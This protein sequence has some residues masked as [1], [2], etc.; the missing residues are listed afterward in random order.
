[1]AED[2]L[3]VVLLLG[4]AVFV[5]VFAAAVLLEMCGIVTL[6]LGGV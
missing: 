4:A 6:I 3:I 5:A 1:M 2:T